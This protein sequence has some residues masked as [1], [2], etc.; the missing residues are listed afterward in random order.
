MKW[1]FLLLLSLP[2]F[3]DSWN[4]TTSGPF[5]AD[6]A[7]AATKGQF[8]Y[9]PWVY[10]YVGTGTS[11]QNTTQYGLGSGWE[12]GTGA[13]TLLGQSTSYKLKIKKTLV[14][15]TDYP[16]WLY[17]PSVAVTLSEAT[18]GTGS[19][20]YQTRG[21]VV[22][23]EKLYPFEVYADAG[24]GDTDALSKFADL[25]FEHVVWDRGQIGY[26]FEVTGSTS[27]TSSYVLAGPEIEATYPDDPEFKAAWGA[28]V[29]LPLAEK[30]YPVKAVPMVTVTFTFR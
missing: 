22:V 16:G 23:R 15:Q 1:L 5:F 7:D 18:P 26:L 21:K 17:V 6:S 11:I 14:S 3:A 2:C 8:V 4:P 12:F 9:E 24:L 30:N 29:V 28:G 13:N 20:S 27:A 19:S 10:D 25:A